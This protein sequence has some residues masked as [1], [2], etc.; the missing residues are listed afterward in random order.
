MCDKCLWQRAP[1]LLGRADRL[2]ERWPRSRIALLGLEPSRPREPEDLVRGDRGAR[3]PGGGRGARPSAPSIA[4]S[5]R[6][7]RSAKYVPA[8]SNPGL[9]MLTYAVTASL[10]SPNSTASEKETVPNFAPPTNLRSVPGEDREQSPELE[11]GLLKESPQPDV[12]S[13]LRE[14]IMR[15]MGVADADWSIGY[16]KTVSV[17]GLPLVASWGGGSFTPRAVADIGR[18]LFAKEIGRANDCSAWPPSARRRATRVC[19]DTA[20]WAG[21]QTRM[22]VIP[23]CRAMRFRGAGAGDQVLL[24]VPSLKLI[25]VRNGETLEPPP[26]LNAGYSKP[27]IFALYHDPRARILFQPLMN[28]VIDSTV[29]P[30][31]PY[32]PS[33]VITGIRW[34]RQSRSSAAHRIATTGR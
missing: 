7:P 13:L 26:T 19:L 4:G 29:R 11:L 25:V 24:V 23:I 32:P 5:Q 30:P 10:R 21:L 6:S 16:G 18:L 2:G 27:D 8:H 14:R 28:A 1:W 33:R 15:P 17:D 20:G 12:R 3:E 9:A 22:A 34:A 31:L